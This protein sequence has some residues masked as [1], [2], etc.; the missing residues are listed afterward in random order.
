M[1]DAAESNGF[2]GHGYIRGMSVVGPLLSSLTGEKLIIEP[3]API[4]VF[5]RF[6]YCRYRVRNVFLKIVGTSATLKFWQD[7]WQTPFGEA[8][9]MLALSAL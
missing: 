2:V 7:S 4:T 3:L 9:L 6:L 5:A 1:I 8:R